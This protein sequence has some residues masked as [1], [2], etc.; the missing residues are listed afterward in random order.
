MAAKQT[1]QITSDIVR[2]FAEALDHG[3]TGS[4]QDFAASEDGQTAARAFQDQK[5]A[6]MRSLRMSWSRAVS[7]DFKV[8]GKLTTYSKD[9]A[10]LLRDYLAT[11]NFDEVPEPD[12]ATTDDETD[13]TAPESAPATA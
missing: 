1:V 13:A 3:F 10:I 5:N 11:V 12:N 7:R 6:E 9:R 8:N 2:A 4:L